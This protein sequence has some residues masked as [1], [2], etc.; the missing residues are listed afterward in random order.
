MASAEINVGAV[1]CVVLLRLSCLF[2]AGSGQLSNLF[3]I[4][5]DSDGYNFFFFMD[6]MF[7]TDILI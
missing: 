3:L 7:E 5:R 4:L 2:H 6:F 1:K